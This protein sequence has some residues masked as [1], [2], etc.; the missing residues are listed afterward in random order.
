MPWDWKLLRAGSFKLDGG[1]MFGIIPAPLWTRLVQP[2]DKNRIP[3]QQNCLL[4]EQ[5][6]KLVLI[7]CG[8]GDKFPQKLR[9]IYAQEERT[10]VDALHE[11]D[12]DPKD[13]ST[14]IVTHLHFDHAGGLTRWKSDGETP[15]LNFPNAEVVCQKTEWNDALNNKSTMH[16]TYLREH[17]DPIRERVRL[18]EGEAEILSGIRALPTPGHTWGQHGVV[19]EDDKGPVCYPGD[20]LPTKNHAGLT[21]NL[22]YDVEPYTN[23]AS[24][25]SLL[26]SASAENWRLALDHE[27]DHAIHT[28]APSQEKQGQYE[29]SP[30]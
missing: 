8:I 4:L 22:A 25:K 18:V 11:I 16:K 24:K 14:V 28:V 30:A 15:E 13:I 2:D 17:L 23:M 7:E 29:L 10:I 3:L 20:V 19:F 12:C 26:T 21:F 1:A 6:G 5:G 27:P 9:D